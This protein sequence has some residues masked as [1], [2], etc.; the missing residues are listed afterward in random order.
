M[1]HWLEFV[2]QEGPEW[3]VLW[4][5]WTG[6]PRMI[7]GSRTSPRLGRADAVAAA[8]LAEHR[9]LF[10]LEHSPLQETTPSLVTFELVGSRDTPAGA[11]VTFQQT[12]RDLPVYDAAVRLLV[13]GEGRIAHIAS[14]SAPD[15]EVSDIIPALEPSAVVSVVEDYVRPQRVT[16]TVQAPGLVI[17]PLGNGRLAYTIVCSIETQGEVWGF[18]V[19]AESGEILRATRLTVNQNSADAAAESGQRT[20]YEGA[21][22]FEVLE[23]EQQPDGRAVG[24][25]HARQDWSGVS[26]GEPLREVRRVAGGV[27]ARS[28][29]AAGLDLHAIR[30]Y[31]CSSVGG[32]EV[33]TPGVGDE[34]YFYFDYECTGTGTTPEYVLVCELDGELYAWTEWAD[35]AGTSWIIHLDAWT[36]TAGT[37]T[38]RWI[39][40][41]EDVVAETNE[42]NNEASKTFTPGGGATLD[43]HAL[44]SYLRSS[45]GGPEVDTP[46]VGDE[47][48]FH[49]EYECTGTGT[50]PEYVLV[51]E[52]D[53]EI[54]E[55]GPWTSEAG[56]GTQI[57][58]VENAW[59]VTAG[60]HTVTWTMDVNDVVDETNES[61]NEATK[62][63]GDT[64]NS[65]V[66]DPNPI[67]ALNECSLQDESD[68][69]SAVPTG[70]YDEVELT[71]LDAPVGGLYSL[72]GDFVSMEHIEPPS[73]APPTSPT[74]SFPYWRC[75]D[76]FEEVMCYHHV[77]TNQI[78]IQSLS[79][80][81]INNRQIRIDA[82]GVGGAD[83]SHYVGLP[84]GAGYVA[85]GD[86]GVDDA[87]D[88]D[89]ILHEYGHAIQ[90]NSS[91]GVYFGSGDVG[92]GDETGA[93]GEGF[94]DYWACSCTHAQSVASGFDPAILAEW[95][96]GCSGLRRVD[97]TKHYPED[98]VDQVHADGEIWSACLWEMFSGIG[99]EVSDRVILQS[100]FL[101]PT[102][103]IFAEGVAAIL[104][105]DD[106]LYGGVHEGTIRG[107]FEARGILGAAECDDTSYT[108]CGSAYAMT[109]GETKSD[110]CG[111]PQYY[112]ITIAA[113]SDVTWTLT[114]NGADFDLYSLWT[115]GSCPSDSE[116]DCRPY[117]AGDE[118]EVC[119]AAELPPGTYHAMVRRYTGAGSYAIS[120]EVG[121]HCVP[122]VSDFTGSPTSGGV[123]LTTSF[124]DS[125][126][127][128][129]TSWAWDFGDGGTSTAQSPSHT[130]QS[131]GSYTVSL[132]VANS[133]G[134]D[135]ET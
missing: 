130:Y 109:D 15:L 43:L 66:F 99:K 98:M 49:L 124:V 17:Y 77:T 59:T 84:V 32:P 25:A 134:S 100:H 60:T 61:N 91:P 31:L 82:H 75:D 3:R 86:G 125:S 122:P 92:Y 16:E 101:V 20:R 73:N 83:N 112:K 115:A 63:I 4:D 44:R 52:L 48:Y 80:T 113:P 94:A 51:V 11:V 107:I 28:G 27:T 8:F 74:S 5:R 104:S 46:E 116:W 81:D 78:Y 40:D 58:Y 89:I 133:C 123:P 42:S 41:A 96:V 118:Q 105:A 64:G 57:I 111:S 39:L 121:P 97:G 65:R 120:V 6:M 47:V 70:A 24:R 30:A 18:V 56:P 62:I 72:V 67:N 1:S 71:L 132:M 110:M 37:H 93:M 13:N 33:E 9:P 79:F 50:T 126:T 22:T 53:G 45:I 135:T 36:A 34:V 131:E 114:P 88:A 7:Y 21:I 12:Y 54:Y 69:C 128:E 29:A 85:F 76:E 10:Y 55:Q 106:M 68:S 119:G 38:V 14:S 2:A 87:E 127:G 90:D 19:D 108:A 26:D 102:D 23:G 103:P 117:L 35:E 129:P 95:D